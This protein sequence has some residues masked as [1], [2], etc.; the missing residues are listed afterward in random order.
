[1]SSLIDVWCDYN[2]ILICFRC[3][4][5]KRGISCQKSQSDINF[6]IF[7]TL[8][9]R[10]R[11]KCQVPGR[12]RDLWSSIVLLKAQCRRESLRQ[13]F[14]LKLEWVACGG[15][16][17]ARRACASSA[18]INSY[19]IKNSFSVFWLVQFF[20]FTA[21]QP[22][23]TCETW[24]RP[25]VLLA[26]SCQD[27]LSLASRRLFSNLFALKWVQGSRTSA[28]TIFST[29]RPIFPVQIFRLQHVFSQMSVDSS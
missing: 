9:N 21:S 18:G 13:L 23:G 8:M 10:A 2:W 28:S 15:N 14:G 7:P 6:V 1:M 27:W 29:R 17:R 11:E 16:Y 24:I 4:R 26:I 5:K 25:G 3:G 19:W 22:L 12:R 20:I